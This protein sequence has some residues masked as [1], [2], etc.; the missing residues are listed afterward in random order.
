MR[1]FFLAPI[2]LISPMIFPE[3]NYSSSDT[4]R[5]PS[6]SINRPSTFGMNNGTAFTDYL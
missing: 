3:I 2:F 6:L 1:F 4:T 5:S